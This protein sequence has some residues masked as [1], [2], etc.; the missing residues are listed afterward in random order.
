MR[1]LDGSIQK[2]CS[3]FNIGDFRLVEC[4]DSG[5]E[6]DFIVF[7]Y[8]QLLQTAYSMDRTETVTVND[9]TTKMF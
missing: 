3:E 8:S 4:L 6:N 1:S 2:V 7:H 9:R 5:T